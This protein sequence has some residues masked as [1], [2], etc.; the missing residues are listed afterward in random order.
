[1]SVAAHE[2]SQADSHQMEIAW[3]IRDDRYQSVRGLAWTTLR[4]LAVRMNPDGTV[5]MTLEE[6]AEHVRTSTRT[7]QR[8][9]RLFRDLGLLVPF[10]PYSPFDPIRFWPALFR[11]GAA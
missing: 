2:P 10:N 7:I 11:K 1:M 8:H 5:D 3:A 9:L 6:I 4:L